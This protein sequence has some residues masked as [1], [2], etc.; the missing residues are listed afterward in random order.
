MPRS[1]IIFLPAFF[2]AVFLL[3]I[4]TA[5]EKIIVKKSK[6]QALITVLNQGD[7]SDGSR[8]LKSIYDKKSRSGVR[9]HEIIEDLVKRN[10]TDIVF[11]ELNLKVGISGTGWREFRKENDCDTCVRRRLKN[12]PKKNS[13]WL[14]FDPNDQVF[15]DREIDPETGSV[16]VFLRLPL[17]VIPDAVYSKF[18][19]VP[20]ITMNMNGPMSSL[21]CPSDYLCGDGRPDE[22]NYTVPDKYKFASLDP[23]ARG[24][25]SCIQELLKYAM[26]DPRGTTSSVDI[27]KEVLT[28]F[29]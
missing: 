22:E 11:D 13:L 8:V 19:T 2:H 15:L 29:F 21:F 28:R 5:V 14:E 12:G 4:F 25:E 20:D 24:F 6:S 16:A 17:L 7:L 9:P 1:L 27:A 10:L 18:A 3:L 26:S 23:L